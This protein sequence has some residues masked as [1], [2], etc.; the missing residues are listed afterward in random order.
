[1]LYAK[2]V[3]K[4]N[5][6][7][8]IGFINNLNKLTKDKFIKDINKKEILLVKNNKGL[9]IKKVGKHERAKNN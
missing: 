1:M 7:K 8:L 3:M 5:V 6:N 9:T 2:N 4:K